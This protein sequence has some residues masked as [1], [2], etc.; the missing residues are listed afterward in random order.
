MEF[1]HMKILYKFSLCKLNSHPIIL[2]KKV[3]KS[4]L[5]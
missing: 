1:S 4:A 5:L 2:I 3:S